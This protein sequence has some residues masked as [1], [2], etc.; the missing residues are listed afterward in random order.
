ML[1]IALIYSIGYTLPAIYSNL[2]TVVLIYQAQIQKVVCVCVGGGGGG[3]GSKNLDF[4]FCFSHHISQRVEGSISIF[5]AGHHRLSS[6][7]PFQWR[8]VIA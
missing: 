3:G 5:L 8:P 7:T 2:V 1:I 4:N 6:E